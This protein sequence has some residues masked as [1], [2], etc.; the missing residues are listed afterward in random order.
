MKALNKLRIRDLLITSLILLAARC[1]RADVLTYNQPPIADAGVSR[2]VATDP[3]RLNGTGSYGLDE[4]GPLFY[5]WKQVSG[6]KL[7]V[8]DANTATPTITGP[9]HIEG[10]KEIS[11]F[12]Q[13]DTLQVC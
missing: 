7:V 8:V 6:P 13:T 4:S 11:N 10:R 9:V 12:I 5:S 1:G 2:Y 3:I